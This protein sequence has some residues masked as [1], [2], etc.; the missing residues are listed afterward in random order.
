[1]L[2]VLI[3]VVVTLV[4]VTMGSDDINECQAGL[5]NC[6]IAAKCIN[7]V[8]SFACECNEG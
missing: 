3:P 6:D 1:M 7:S 5:H 4:A 2:H 8:G